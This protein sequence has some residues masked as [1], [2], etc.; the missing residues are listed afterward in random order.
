MQSTVIPSRSLSSLPKLPRKKGPPASLRIDT[1]AQN[2]SIALARGDSSASNSAVSPATSE[3]GSFQFPPPSRSRS[4]RNMNRLSLTLSSA[5]SSTSSL[6]IPPPEPPSVPR[7]E[8]PAFERRRRP[9]VVSLPISTSSLMLRREEDGSPSAPYIDGPVEVLPKIWLGAEDN[10]HDWAGL[11]ERSIGAIL[12]VAKEVVSPFDA[13]TPQSLDP[14]QPNTF[15]PPHNGRPGMRYL[16]LQWSHGQSDLVQR[17]FDEAMSFVDRSVERG[18]G[19]LIHCQCGISRSATLVIALVMRAATLRS[20]SV[21]PQVWE[22][23][24]MQAAYAYVKEKS[25]WVGPNMSLIYQLLEYERV[26]RGDSASTAESESSY[27]DP[28][29]ADEAWGRRRQMMEDSSDREPEETDQEIVEVQREARALDKAMEDR[30]IARKSSS[31]SVGSGLGMGTAWRNRYSSRKRTGSISS[32]VTSNSVISED[33]VEEDEE[34]ELLGTG[35]GFDRTSIDTTSPRP[36]EEETSDASS[37]LGFGPDQATPM[38]SRMT[39]QFSRV[40]PSAPAAK[41]TFT[42]PPVPATA[43][44]STFDLPSRSTSMSKPKPKRRPAPLGM[45]PP[46]PDSP[47]IVIEVSDPAPVRPLATPTRQRKE[48]RKLA[49]PPLSLRKASYNMQPP[50]SSATSQSSVSTPSQ[51]LFVFPPSPT[52]TTSS[53]TPSAMTLT[54]NLS[55]IFPSVVTPRV[56]TFKTAG[57]SRSYIGIMAPPTPTT[58]HARVDARGWVGMS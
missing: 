48:S 44:R 21:P 28:A 19:V 56:S 14:D 6:A 2:P 57:R 46:V 24:G 31:S 51:T 4:S 45:L 36:A 25:Q 38:A 17:G 22:L 7:T 10:V 39:R 58:A 47:S 20:P 50:L 9:S 18:E 34:P 12:N 33:L 26:L 29:D 49:L 52:T 54:S 30:I 43:F 8:P 1:P 42:L 40:P 41:S 13:L 37:E 32:N 11:A 35:G 27:N 5:Q 3:S 23:K 55:V 53:R 15:Y 16:K